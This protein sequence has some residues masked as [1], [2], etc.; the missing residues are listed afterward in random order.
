VGKRGPKLKNEINLKW[1]PELAYA[2]GLLVTDGNVSKDGRHI[3][4]VSKD[5]EQINNFNKCLGV[6]PKLGKTVSSY[7]GKSYHRVQLGN[8]IFYKFLLSIGIMPAKSK[9]VGKILLPG[10]YFF[11]FLRGC[12]DGDGSFYSYWDKRWRSSFM[13]YLTFNSASY[14]HILWIRKEIFKHLFINGY[15]SKSR[16]KGSIYGLRYAKKESLVI[17]KK[18]YYNPKVVSLSRKHIKIK[19]ALNI[20][21]KQ[22][23]KYARVM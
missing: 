11:D 22:Q 23:R 12:F 1:R 19:K 20:N 9:I 18:M 8:I 5:I 10:K 14:S 7:D 3:I 6:K 2:V 4:F 21:R 16:W 15:I 17:I 13:F